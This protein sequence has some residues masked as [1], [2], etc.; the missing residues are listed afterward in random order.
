L[1]TAVV[2]AASVVLIV[3]VLPRTGTTQGPL[4]DGLETRWDSGTGGGGPALPGQFLATTI[5][6]PK[7]TGSED[8]VLD[9]IE[10]VRPEQARGLTVRYALL[11]EG[12]PGSDRGWPPRGRSVPVEGGH[13]RPG[14]YG[15]IWVGMA[16]HELGDWKLLNFRLRYHIGDRRYETVIHQAASVQVVEKCDGCRGT[17][18][19]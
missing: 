12:T 14:A 4:A 18:Q 8:A 13:I 11:T 1:A 9:S 10:L 15:F 16:S 2:V 6:T 5:D 3:V 19:P 17:D 7:L